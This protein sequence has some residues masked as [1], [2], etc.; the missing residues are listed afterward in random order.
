[1]LTKKVVAVSGGAGLIGSEFSRAIVQSGGKVIIGDI[2]KER[3]QLLEK[4]LCSESSVFIELDT[5]A[6]DSIDRFIEKGVECFGGIDAAVHCSYPR[7]GQWGARFEDLKFE[8]LSNDL[9]WQLGGAIMFSQKFITYFRGRN[10]GNL[11]HLGSIQ[12]IF[13]PKFD[14]YDGTEM[15]SPIE[16]SAIKAGVISITKYI[17]K[18]CK[19]E[20]IR[21]N[22][23]SP[24][25]IINE[26]P[27]G[28]LKKYREAC[29][30]KGML[31]AKDLNGALLYLLSDSSIYMNGQNLI[32]DDGWGL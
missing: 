9:S 27:K 28:F 7:S 21:A 8:D 11:V 25:G 17:A 26:Q 4:E 13:A 31:H 2:D 22:C 19:G 16:Y 32:V 18:Y 5:T 10:G 6:P 12:G 30:S 14:H 1:V 23:I 15:V 29:S 20:N 24:G 3:G